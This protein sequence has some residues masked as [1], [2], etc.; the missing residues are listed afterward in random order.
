MATPDALEDDRPER[1]QVDFTG[2]TLGTGYR[3]LRRLA[4]GG[5]GSV[6]LAHDMSLGRDVVVKVPHARFLGERGFRT[7]FH[8]EISELVRLEHLHVVRILAKGEEDGVPYYVLTYLRGGSLEDRLKEGRQTPEAAR[9]WFDTVAGTLDFVHSRGV[10]HRD[11]KP[12]NILFDEQGNVYLSDFGLVKALEDREGDLTEAGSGVGSPFYMAPEQGLGREVTPAADQYALA[13]TLYEALAGAPPVGHGTAV[14][15]LIRK[16]REVP[17]PLREAVPGLPEASDAAVRRALSRDPTQ[18]FS[19]CAA[20][21][22]AFASGFAPPPPAPARRK[23]APYIVAFALLTA[24]LAAAVATRGFGLGSS[25]EAPA[26]NALPPDTILHL[27][28]AGEAP[29]RLLR[30][31]LAPGT[32]QRLEIATRSVMES[33]ANSPIGKTLQLASEQSVEAKVGDGR[34]AWRFDPLRQRPSEHAT[35]QEAASREA[36]DAQARLVTGSAVPLPGGG[37]SQ[38]SL[39]AEGPPLA[40]NSDPVDEVRDWFRFLT[41]VLPR[42]PVGVGAEW[43]VTQLASAGGLRFQEETTFRLV[44]F[45]GDRVRLHVSS[46][47]TAPDQA[48]PLPGLPADG[49]PGRMHL[50]SASGQ[51]DL[52]LALDRPGIVEYVAD[53]DVSLE[54]SRAGT[55]GAPPFR[56]DDRIHVE[57]RERAP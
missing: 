22:E 35:P 4:E 44:A 45:E 18:R 42:E 49:G 12:G 24:L 27:A 51:G 33:A 5:M 25:D 50:V 38:I 32:V 37:Q 55:A 14:E 1:F 53:T 28:G 6:Y 54:L 15:G 9:A 39:A 57:I 7:R 30:Y 40:P 36:L 17:R 29:R 41:V 46:R 2:R 21:A 48:F 26:A 43:D 56:V 11:V 34:V 47:N 13:S 23:T 19:S 3:V 31:A 20:F 10:I 8:R 16:V 52:L